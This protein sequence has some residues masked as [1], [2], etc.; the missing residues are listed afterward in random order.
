VRESGL[1]LRGLAG[2]MAGG[3]CLSITLLTWYGYHA[4]R[5]WRRSTV[6]LNQQRAD[7]AADLLA[8]ALARD[9]RAVQT[10]VLSSHDWEALMLNAPYDAA[11]VV[12][13]AFARYPYPESFFAW[14]E[15]QTPSAI[16]F[17][18]RSA[19]PPAWATQE[20]VRH[21]FPVT[22]LTNPAVG[23]TIAIQVEDD[24]RR[25]RRFSIFE[26]KIADVDCQVVTQLFYR[27]QF[28]EQLGGAFGFTVNLPWVRRYYFQELTGQVARIGSTREGLTL[29][30][31]DERGDRVAMTDAQAQSAPV[32]QRTFQMMFF[33][34]LVVALDPTNTISRRPWTVRVGLSDE[35]LAASSIAV[36]NRTL[37]VAALAVGTLALGLVLTARATR[38]SAQL[39]EMRSEFVSTVTHELK[40][41]IATI[42][43]VG[44][45]LV[46]GRVM[47]ADTLR[48]YPRIIVQESKRLTRLIDNLLAYARIAD[49]TE[50]YSFEAVDVSGLVDEIQQEFCSQLASGHFAVAVDIP[51]TIPPIWA[52]HTAVELM[53]NNLIDNAIR[54]SDVRRSIAI[55]AH[56]DGAMVAIEIGDRGVGISE[57][58]IPHVVRRF[59][60]GRRSGSGGSGLGLAIA[61]RI[62]ADHGGKLT[63][64]SAVDVGTTVTVM[65]PV[66][67]SDA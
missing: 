63:I 59:V 18:N 32:S 61:N 65:L 21:R 39:S 10:S 43:A 20:D 4:I 12:A 27:D 24:A 48:D 58:E 17:F 26:A 35:G 13:S 23:R 29:A 60:R 40:T 25:R 38:A 54:Y 52:D 51:Y 19:R 62:A 31:V 50:A 44:D 56:H 37:I 36:I 28:R 2:W 15:G 47:T 6:Q 9:M 67:E 11:D 34:P 22:M 5:E 53:L 41:P 8:T 45:T 46:S 66:A 57:D 64:R 16:I 33:D 1:S 14:R 55:R 30:I 42:R 7:Q 3:V 49:V